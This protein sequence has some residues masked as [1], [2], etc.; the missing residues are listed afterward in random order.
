MSCY[1]TLTVYEVMY[2][3]G[4]SGDPVHEGGQSGQGRHVGNARTTGG[5]GGDSD[6][7]PSTPAHADPAF[8]PSKAEEILGG[9]DPYAGASTIQD[10]APMS[11]SATTASIKSGIPGETQTGK[12]L[13]ED[14]YR[15]K[16][17]VSSSTGNTTA[18]P[19]SSDIGN[20]ADPR[21]DSDL[22][23]RGGLKGTPATTDTKGYTTGVDNST[24]LP[25]RSVQG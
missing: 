18:G 2:G 7:T 9:Q 10:P 3:S 24:A 17:G 11:D 25:D 5:F 19:H 22:D 16:S 14:T 8:K 15:A 1:N 13:G 6:P 21:V 23:G 4:Q 12:G 20:K